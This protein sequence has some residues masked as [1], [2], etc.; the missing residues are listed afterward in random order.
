MPLGQSAA[1]RALT[2]VYATIISKWVTASGKDKGR[3]E[4]A[5]GLTADFGFATGC[6]LASCHGVGQAGGFAD[7]GYV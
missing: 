1:P 6:Q 7:A 2:S 4:G 5:E 3:Y